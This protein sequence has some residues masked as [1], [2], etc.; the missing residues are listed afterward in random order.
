MGFLKLCFY[1][2]FLKRTG[3]FEIIPPTTP[4]LKPLTQK[5]R[6]FKKLSLD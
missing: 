5:E 6:F 4:Q 3:D 2:K 1:N